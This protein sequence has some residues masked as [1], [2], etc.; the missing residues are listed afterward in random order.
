[1]SSSERMACSSLALELEGTQNLHTTS[2]CEHLKLLEEVR[3][4]SCTL[5]DL[6]SSTGLLFY[7]SNNLFVEEYPLHLIDERC[8]VEEDRCMKRSLRS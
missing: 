3:C 2:N 6:S 4:S 7:S 8:S 5:D 1:M